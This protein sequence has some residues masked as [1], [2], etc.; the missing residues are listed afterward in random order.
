MPTPNSLNQE[1]H[2]G[3][4]NAKKVIILDASKNQITSFG[5]STADGTTFTQN[6]TTG[7]ISMGVYQ[8]SPDTIT[9]GKAAAIGIDANRN[10]KVTQGTLLAGENL[11][12]N[13]L[14]N[15]PIYSYT[16]ITT[17]TTTT[18][19]SGAGTLAGFLIPTPVASATMKIF[20]NTAA[21]GSVIVD[22][23]TFPA[24]LVSD[25]PVFIKIDAS[26]AIGC[27]VVTAGA[28][29]AADIYYR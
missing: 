26:F 11:T 9:T 12:T 15:E 22:T 17:Q 27:T 25:G 24:T 13:R 20:D 21:S 29:M 8:S 28:T 3:T 5:A 2:D 10:S 16:S 6:T 23:I 19:K 18:V 7:G 14:N 1:E 4:T